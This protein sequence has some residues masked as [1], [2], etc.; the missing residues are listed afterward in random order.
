MVYIQFNNRLMNKRE[1]IKSKK[2]LM[3]SCLVIQ[4]KLKVFSKRMEMIVH[5][6]SLEMKTRMRW[7]V[8]GYLGL[9]LERQ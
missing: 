2:S 4:L 3:F 9:L 6:L 7:K 5:Y 1:K 8:Q